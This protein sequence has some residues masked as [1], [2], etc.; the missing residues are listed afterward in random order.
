MTKDSSKSNQRDFFAF[1]DLIRPFAVDRRSL[2]ESA[3]TGEIFRRI[4]DDGQIAE[5]VAL[6]GLEIKTAITLD[7]LVVTAPDN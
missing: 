7:C 3:L 2:P 4:C 5:F 1:V 6:R